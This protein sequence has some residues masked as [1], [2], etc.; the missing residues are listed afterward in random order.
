MLSLKVLILL[1]IV[2]S[3][4][5]TSFSFGP[6]CSAQVE[7]E[8]ADLSR[9]I[10][11]ADNSSKIQ[12]AINSAAPG[13]TVYVKDGIYDEQLLINKSLTL[14]GQ[15]SSA[16]VIEG[17]LDK[18]TITVTADNVTISGF[19]VEKWGNPT[20]PLYWGIV[21]QNTHEATISDNVLTENFGGVEI[22]GG[23]NNIVEH[24][25]ITGN[26]YGVFLSTF[27][28]N[29][30]TRIFATNNTVFDNVV[31]DSVWNGVELDWGGGNV[32]YENTIVNSTA[33][34]LEIPA[35]SPSLNNVIYHNNF[36]DNAHSVEEGSTSYQAYGPLPNSWDFQGEGNYWS[37]YKGMDTDHDGIGDTPVK[38]D[39]GTI[40]YDPLMGNFSDITAS[41]FHFG[42]VSNSSIISSDFEV[43][44]TE[45]DL[46]MNILPTGNSTG[47]CRVTIPKKAI[48]EPYQIELDGKIVSYPQA[49]ELSSSNNT[50]ECLYVEIG[51]GQHTLEI[52]GTETVSEFQ[53]T[54]L[55]VFGTL[56][57]LVFALLKKRERSRQNRY[58]NLPLV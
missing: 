46:S 21:L 3:L 9:T 23:F 19:T 50:D 54:S 40:D 49:K 13:D 14:T 22:A 6:A 1:A 25:L 20:M 56:T 32:I 45:A 43:N 4:V 55:A 41:T 51:S 17:P 2:F 36:I 15:N 37:D 53:L 47:F 33:W 5:R 24:N 8:P 18:N 57:L 29:G 39:Y 48:A 12:D 42:V 26:R 38:T 16:T 30:E 58:S 52:I 27:L 7:S 44:G 10:I 11:V 28:E 35:Y 31:S 34:G